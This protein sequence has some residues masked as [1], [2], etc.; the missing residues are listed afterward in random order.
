MQEEELQIFWLKLI[1]FPKNQNFR[2]FNLLKNIIFIKNF[3]KMYEFNRKSPINI[4][5]KSNQN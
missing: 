3:M 1:N 2:I 5:V 4:Q